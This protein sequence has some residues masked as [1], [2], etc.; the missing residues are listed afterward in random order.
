M[1]EERKQ[2]MAEGRTQG[3]KKAGREESKG[4]ER[5]EHKHIKAKGFI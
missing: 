5:A 2:G 3:K 1:K 4:K